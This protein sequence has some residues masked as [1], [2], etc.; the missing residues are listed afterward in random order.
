MQICLTYIRAAGQGDDGSR[1]ARDHSRPAKI[2]VAL[3]DASD[4]LADVATWAKNAK[5]GRDSSES[6]QWQ[7][8]RDHGGHAVCSKG[9][10]DC[11][12]SRDT[13]LQAI[14]A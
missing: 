11:P 1:D 4:L 5:K 3:H 2:I 12:I 13:K 9:G 7:Q 8:R 6:E 14:P 10:S